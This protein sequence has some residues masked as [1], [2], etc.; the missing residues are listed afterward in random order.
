MTK[1]SFELWGMQLLEPMGFLL[2]MVMCLFSFALFFRLKDEEVSEFKKHWINFYWLF[3]LSTLF[4]GFSHLLYN[5]LGMMGKVPGWLA[6]VF[7][8]ASIEMAVATQHPDKEGLLKRII[9]FKA[10]VVLVL[11]AIDLH[12]TWVMIQTASGL[13]II[14]GI[15]SIHHVKRGQGHYLLFL[16]GIGLMILTLPFRLGQ[17]DLHL[18]FNR[19]DIS[20]VFMICTLALMYKGVKHSELKLQATT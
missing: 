1:I 5:Y 16:Y 12:F 2:N 19:D 11:M 18:W 10:I 17:I 6:A 3:A 13:L 9:R 14:L 8:I 4:G 20:H 7:A 15:S